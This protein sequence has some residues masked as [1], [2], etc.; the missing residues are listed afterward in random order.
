M[1]TLLPITFQGVDEGSNPKAL[2]PGTLTDDENVRMDKGRRLLKRLG[3]NPITRALLEGGSLSAGLRLVSRGDDL[4]VYDGE[5]LRTYSPELGVWQ[6][7]GRPSNLRMTHRGL[8]DSTRSASAADVALYGNLL[9][10]VFV[11]GFSAT[12]G[13]TL[14]LQVENIDTGA[15]VLP[16]L[17]VGRYAAWPRVLISGTEAVVVYSTD[18]GTGGG[19]VTARKVSLTT[20]AIVSGAALTTTSVIR[21]PCDA[22]ITTPSGGVPTLYVGYSMPS[23]TDRFQIAGYLVSTLGLTFGPDAFATTS[24]AVT[25]VCVEA[26]PEAVHAVYIAFISSTT[27]LVS[28]DPTLASHTGPTSVGGASKY[29]SVS[30]YDS[31]RLLVSVVA[32]DSASSIPFSLITQLRSIAAHTQDAASVRTSYHVVAIGK[33]FTLGSRWY[34]HALLAPKDNSLVTNTT[35]PNASSVIL[36]IETTASITS[37]TGSPHHQV[38]TAENLTGWF[39]TVV[40]YM[41]QAV[42]NGSVAYVVAPYRNREP[43][44]FQSIPIGFNLHKIEL[45]AADTHRIAT[46]GQGG[47]AAAAS[48]YWTDGASAMPYGH[49]HAP[50]I[51][52]VS[53]AGTGGS[54]AAGTYGY[55]ACYEWRDTNGVLH[56]SIPS[57]PRFNT[58]PLVAGEVMTVKV[59]TASIGQHQGPPYGVANADAA[60]PVSVVLFRTVADGGNGADYYRLTLE[61][62]YQVLI[63]DPTAGFVTLTDTKADADIGNGAPL[64]P[65]SAQL[66]IY[67]AKEVDDIP[68]PS[69]ITVAPFG[70]RIVGIDGSLRMLWFTKDQ[71]EDPQ[72]APGFNETLTR[73]FPHD[74]TA[75]APLD[76]ALIVF[77][78]DSI[79]IITGIGPDRTGTSGSWEID[80]VQADVGCVNPRSPVTLPMGVAFESSRGLELISRDKTISWIGKP[81]EDTLAAYPVIT[82]AVLVADHHEIRFTCNTQDGTSGIVLAWDYLN[83]IWFTRRYK[84]TAVTSNVAVPFVDSQLIGGVYTMLTA[85]GQVYQETSAHALD[86]GTSYVQSRVRTALTG[87][88]SATGRARVKDMLLVGDNLSKHK[89]EVVVRHDFSTA[90]WTQTKDFNEET[91]AT[92]VG[93]EAARVTFKRQKCQSIEVEIR[94][95]AP[96]SA[97][98]YGTGEGHALEALSFRVTPK[99]GPAKTAAGQQG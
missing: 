2:P 68:P 4:T 47:L 83:K 32:S 73:G 30:V 72:V 27:N 99:E 8:I 17:L 34:V 53:S 77:G 52:A 21:G 26:T 81:K 90:A 61:P 16:P 1:S 18:N 41:P 55:V 19:Q 46:A 82:S 58:T 59:S 15:K 38:G 13:G 23:G 79:D 96:S 85:G 48:P 28:L 84:D 88:G 3:T 97:A 42:V 24:Q 7:V 80:R 9:V 36:E 11:A 70:G 22:S 40:G 75:L 76:A 37:T 63:N 50:M 65:L 10:T 44:N 92:T 87:G 95:L 25:S 56:R 93:L 54:M 60:T 64:H 86:G 39:P 43:T 14:Y 67:T 89:I 33:P 5:Y 71:T 57:P 31:T 6:R 51:L 35:I 91:L 66:Q 78:P 94:D 29:A 12:L 45:N 20:L 69:L 98:D 49:P 74:K 62:E